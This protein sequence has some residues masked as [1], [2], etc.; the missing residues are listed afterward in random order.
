MAML[1]LLGGGAGTNVSSSNPAT[2]ARGEAGVADESLA[3]SSASST[4]EPATEPL[5][6]AVSVGG[7]SSDNSKS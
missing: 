5:R 7:T 3:K 2:R 6:A 4:D 1:Y